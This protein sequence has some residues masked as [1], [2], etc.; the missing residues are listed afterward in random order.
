MVN[1]K[2]QDAPNKVDDELFPPAGVALL[3]FDF[4]LICK[5]VFSLQVLPVQHSISQDLQKHTKKVNPQIFDDINF[6]TKLMLW[7]FKF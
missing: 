4:F 1:M 3:L 6:E 2:F 7:I 5:I